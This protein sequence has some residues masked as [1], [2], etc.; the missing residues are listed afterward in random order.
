[1]SCKVQI[2]MLSIAK[3]TW[4]SLAF[5]MESRISRLRQSTALV[6]AGATSIVLTNSVQADVQFQDLAF[7]PVGV[8]GRLI[9][10]HNG[11]FYGVT[12]SGG[13]Y[14]N[15]AVFK[16][17]P[18]GTL[19]NLCSFNGTNGDEPIGMLLQGNDGNFY[20]TTYGGGVN[21]YGTVFEM[22]PMGDLKTLYSFGNANAPVY[23][24]ADGAN[25]EA[26]LVQD[27]DGN[28][29]G[30]ACVG[31]PNT[32]GTIF[33]ITS[34]GDF[35][36][37][38]SFTADNGSGQNLD[39]ENPWGLVM[40]YDGN[41]YGTTPEGG[42]Y[43]YGTVF[44]MTP[45][46]ILTNLFSFDGTNGSQ[47]FGLMEG[48]DGNFY[49]VTQYNEVQGSTVGWGTAFRISSSGSCTNLVSFNSFFGPNGANPQGGL[50][51][52][53]DGNFY[54]TTAYGGTSESWG[55]IFEMTADGTLTT[56][57]TFTGGTDGGHPAAAMV[58]GTNGVL[59]GT[60]SVW[61]TGGYGTIFQI[62]VPPPP[63]PIFQAITRI[64]PTL[65]LNW[66]AL[67]GACYQLQYTCDLNSSNWTNLGPLIATTNASITVT[68]SATNSQRIYRVYIR[69]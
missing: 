30:A 25:P 16:M 55:T 60:T 33:K 53:S 26:G 5:R 29:Y 50:L 3:S 14:G 63:P 61:K 49:G 11:N 7:F 1:M 51:Q 27:S 17:T 64:G 38:H 2:R 58:Q 40:G 66:T 59:F 39:G 35:T 23:T 12:S 68:D 43:G 19:T 15:G 6:L 36:N 37:L 67:W 10:G 20:G 46:G 54:G 22:T 47:P 65:T 34:S 21:G 56:L 13:S 4:R 32:T 52:A 44:K 28:F 8:A 31:G 42:A 69:W 18:S 24:N 45:G 48:N 62:S 41:I 9:Q 57:Y